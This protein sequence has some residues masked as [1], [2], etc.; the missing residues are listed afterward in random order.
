MGEQQPADPNFFPEISISV[1][2]GIRFIV[3]KT[4][5]LCSYFPEKGYPS[6]RGAAAMLD[7]ALCPDEVPPPEMRLP[8]FDGNG[9]Y[10]EA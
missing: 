5:G 4:I 8:G 7:A 9:E 1:V 6:E 10:Q 2:D 3:R